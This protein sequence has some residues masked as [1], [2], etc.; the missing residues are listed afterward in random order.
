M[1]KLSR[2]IA[3]SGFLWGLLPGVQAEQSSLTGSSLGIAQAASG[4]SVTQ[5]YRLR[6]QWS[7][8]E[9]MATKDPAIYFYLNMGEVMPHA[10]LARAGAVRE[11]E[12]KPLASIGSVRLSG[13]S[14]EMTLDEMLNPSFS[15][16]QGVV[17]VH[18]G[19]IAYERYPGMR[20][21]DNHVWMSNAKTIAGLLIALLEEDGLLNVQESIDTY[22]PELANTSWKDISVVDILNMASGLDLAE[23][24]SQ[25]R[26][27][28]SGIVRLFQTEV[29]DKDADG[30]KRTHNE[31]LFAFPKLKEPGQVFEYS[32]ANTQMLGLLIE[33]VTGQRLSDVISERIWSKMGS[34]GDGLLGLTPDG[35]PII[36][37]IVSSRLRDMA[38]YGMLFTPSWSHVASEPIVS[39]NILTKIQQGGNPENYYKGEIGSRIAEML[40]DKPIH[41][42]YQWDAVFADGDFFKGGMRGQGLY[43]S[44]AR[45]L[46]ITWFASGDAAIPMAAFAR[47]IAK[48]RFSE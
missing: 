9:F 24:E 23:S 44:P 4:F 16:V 48:T 42:S 31:V 39:A 22:I 35:N 45:D 5:A 6:P 15:P 46:V 8:T 30:I 10:V 36:H 18:K 21:S 43:V 32:S 47:Q 17:V 11:L 27:P 13:P 1:K 2:L 14:G 37:G 25:R 19:A 34:E 38:R 20:P 40:Q 3:V 28:N 41:N 29:G 33:R 26:N 7:M 12:E